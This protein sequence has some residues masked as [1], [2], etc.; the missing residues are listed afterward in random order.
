MSLSLAKGAAF[1]S[2]KGWGGW[3]GEILGRV[4]TFLP[5]Q[6][7]RVSINL[8][9]QRGGALKFYCFSGEGHIF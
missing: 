7:E 5:A 9:Q 1:I 6:K 4:I 3:A 2:K 8:T